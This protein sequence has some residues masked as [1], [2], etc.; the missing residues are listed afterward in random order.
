MCFAL[1]NYSEGRPGS[2]E[3]G[4]DGPSFVEKEI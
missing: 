3:Q 4:E 1:N 2:W